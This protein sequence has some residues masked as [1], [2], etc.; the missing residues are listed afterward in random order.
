MTDQL[1]KYISLLKQKGAVYVK[2]IDTDTIVVAPWT[3]MK[4]RYGCPRYGK[5]RSCPPFAPA[6]EETQKI[7]QCYSHAILFSV[8]SMDSGTPIALECA[9]ALTN[10]GFYKVIAFGT[11]PCTLCK[12]CSLADC[13]QPHR[14]APSM[15]ACGIDVVATVRAA[16]FPINIPPKPDEPL[17]C[18]GLLLV[19]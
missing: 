7:L 11:G 18:Y 15:E 17:N 6:A 14:V 8:S 2:T 12:E 4:C 5:N 3:I 19:D 1:H 13:P 9:S 10:D 16:G